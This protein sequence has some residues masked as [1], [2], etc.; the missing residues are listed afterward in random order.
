[1]VSELF[2]LISHQP[3]IDKIYLYVKDPYGT[4]YQLL[5]NKSENSK[6]FIEYLNDMDDI[7][8]NIE[9][10]NPGN[11]RKILIL[12]DKMIADMLSIY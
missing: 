7:Y 4:K 10:Y 6:V 3:D 1:M 9:E 8:K 5:I 12:F 2:S 11:E